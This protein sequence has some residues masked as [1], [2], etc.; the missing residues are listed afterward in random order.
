MLTF[1]FCLALIIPAPA[2]E[3]PLAIYASLSTSE[4]LPG[5]TFSATLSVYSTSA[6]PLSLELDAPTP[7]GMTLLATRWTTDT[8]QYDKP[9]TI[10]LAYRVDQIP[11]DGRFQI[12][13]Y[14]VKDG[15]GHL[16]ARWVQLRVGTV[17]WT[18]QNHRLFLPVVV[19]SPAI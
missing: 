16:A 14:T 2:A 12:M 8:I 15:A 18:R 7:I 19:G 13:A 17:D 4:V 1:L 5:G 9:V 10:T 6:D 3:P 11:P